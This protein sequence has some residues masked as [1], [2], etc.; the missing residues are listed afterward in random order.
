MD[1]CYAIYKQLFIDGY[2]FSYNLEE[3]GHYFLAYHH[4]MEH[5]NL[6]MPG[7][8][9]TVNYEKLVNDVEGESR[10]LLDYCGLAWQDGCLR[11]YE[12]SQASSTASAAQIRQPVYQS[13]VAKW[14][15]YEEQLA[16][17]IKLLREAGIP[18]D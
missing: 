1:A 10:S 3:L 6:V 14:T 5:W 7:V 8:I 12:N 11:F 9:H 2:P 15:R 17:L 13:S 18:L 4:L 16:P